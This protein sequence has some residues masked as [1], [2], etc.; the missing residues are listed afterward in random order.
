MQMLN[1]QVTPTRAVTKQ[2]PHLLKSARI[3]LA[4]FGSAA[5]APGAIG[6]VGPA[7][8]K[9]CGIHW[10]ASRAHIGAAL[11]PHNPLVLISRLKFSI[12]RII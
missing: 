5:R 9:R 10:K 6:T 11:N 4:A 3:D 1:Q 7:T 8:R 12:V 2:H